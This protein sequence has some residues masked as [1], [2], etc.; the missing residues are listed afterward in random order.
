MDELLDI[1]S[2][3]E[4]PVAYLVL[5]LSAMLEYVFPPFPGDTVALFGAFLI[6]ARGWN[7]L[8]VIGAITGGSLVGAWLDFAVGVA[9]A[10]APDWEPRTWVG[11]R[12]QRTWTR[13]EPLTKRLHERG[14]WYIVVN[15]F[16][17]GIRALF[18]VAAGMAGLR[19]RAV[20]LWGA[21]S[22]MLWNAVII[23]V[24]V[25]IGANWERLQAI[26]RTYTTAAWVLIGLVAAALVVRWLIRHLRARG[27]S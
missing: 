25:T 20:L 4:G 27:E 7:A 8:L 9:L 6:T 15:R 3:S 16:L 17:P 5:A 11:R 26:F 1:I 24:G 14:A 13:V 21:L 23:A 10:K 19:L 22:A 18:F 2:G 12:W